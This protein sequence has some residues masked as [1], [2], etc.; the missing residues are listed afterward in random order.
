MGC[1]D[2]EG[3]MNVPDQL[4]AFLSLLK[5]LLEEAVACAFFLF[6]F[7]HALWQGS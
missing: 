2:K 7:G 4:W 5:S 6:L 1:S 3:D